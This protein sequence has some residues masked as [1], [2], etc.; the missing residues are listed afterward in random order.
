MCT[1]FHDF[2]LLSGIVIL[3]QRDVF[4]SFC[5]KI[6]TYDERR[7]HEQKVKLDAI[8]DFLELNLDICFVKKQ[9][10]KFISTQFLFFPFTV[11]K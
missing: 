3:V 2:S 9:N 5:Y 8:R 11:Y 1:I 6:E 10:Y 7:E 4:S